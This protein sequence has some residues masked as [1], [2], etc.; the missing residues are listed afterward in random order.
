MANLCTKFEV[1]SFS[2]SKAILEAKKLKLVTW[3]DHALLGM[4]CHLICFNQ[5]VHQIWSIYV[6]Q[7][8]RYRTKCKM[9]TL[10][11]FRMVR[12]HQKS[13]ETWPFD[14]VH[15][16]S[17]S[18]VKEAMCLSRTVFKLQWVYLSKVEDLNQPYVHLVPS[19]GVNPFE[20]HW[21]LWCWCQKTRFPAVSCGIVYVIIS[22]TTL[23]QHRREMDAQTHNDNIILC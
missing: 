7:P 16:T 1:S 3:R 10:G 8:Q 5:P 17:H 21:D 9:L 6:R 11:W 20:F 4:I 13:S 23:K 19:L 14:E 18:T 12:G 2:H 15:M 22:L